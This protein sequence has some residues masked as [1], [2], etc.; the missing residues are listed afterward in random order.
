[1]IYAISIPFV[2]MLIVFIGYRL[3]ADGANSLKVKQLEKVS[4]DVKKAKHVR[5]ML[6][7]NPNK[8][9]RLRKRYSRKQLL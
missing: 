9:K 7:A 5:D 4:S 3:R 2:L 6:N 1:M 8:R